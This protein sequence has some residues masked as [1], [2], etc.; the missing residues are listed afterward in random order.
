MNINLNN[1]TEKAREAVFEA[2]NE[3]GR[4]NH[5]QI[6]GLHL[7]YALITQEQGITRALLEKMNITPNAVELAR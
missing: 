5:Q 3:A 6:D 4:R 7:L 1:Y 2:Q